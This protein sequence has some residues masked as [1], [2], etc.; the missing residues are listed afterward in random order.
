MWREYIQRV[1]H[2][3]GHVVRQPWH[4]LDRWQRAARFSYDL[5]RFGTRQ[6][7]E[8]RAPQMAAA[9]AFQTLF[10]LV[11]VLVAAM[12][13]VQAFTRWDDFVQTANNLLISAGLSEVTVTLVTADASEPKV[14]SLQTWLVGLI[15]QA[16]NVDL[17]VIGPVGFLV[18]L[19]AGISML[20]TIE[21]SF[22]II[23][24][25]PQG[26]PW[27][28]RIPLYWF[29][30]TVSPL[31]LTSEAWI[32]GHVVA[33]AGQLIPGDWF[34]RGVGIGWSI[35]IGWLFWFAVYSLVPN[36]VVNLRSTA[37]GA[38]VCVLLLEIAKHSLGA[39]L[40]N[41]FTVS[42]FYG[43]L[44]LIPLFMFWVYLMWLFVL[45]GL[46]VAAT[47]Q[48]L[49]DRALEEIETRREFAGLVEPAAVITVMEVV[50]EDF[51]VGQSTTQRRISD[52]TGV[53]ERIV[54]SIMQELSAAGLVHRLERDQSTVCL[55]L[56]PEEIKADRLIDIG[57]RLADHSG[58]R[59]ISHF[60]E[61][62]REQQRALAGAV[63]LASLLPAR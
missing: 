5:G 4:E 26:R 43:S 3:I 46:E 17:T 27:S 54:Q 44:G 25:A 14:V 9:L 51:H 47:L 28:R 21:N 35:A 42:K 32:H 11:P 33:A 40:S 18:I 20:T 6:L 58:E 61:R 34:G 10:A 22:N 62:L 50:A 53:P 48:F 31:A 30:I 57:F 7:R 23:Y 52:R 41:A 55:A 49:G 19:Y 56:P 2:W 38:F 13:I 24:R 37:V 15:Q 16:A 63:T 12:V 29:L 1:L 39:Y 60:A 36:T 59:A 45:F 8:D